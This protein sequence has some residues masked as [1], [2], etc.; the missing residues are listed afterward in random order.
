MNLKPG[1]RLKQY[2]ILE[3]IGAGGM[4]E[5]YR[6][7][8]TNLERD[9][10]IKVLPPEVAETAT[11]LAR[12]EREAKSIAVAAADDPELLELMRHVQ[13]LVAFATEQMKVIE[14]L[15]D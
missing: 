14:A 10:A 7:L 15:A 8:D 12:L 4:G 13:A 2:E 9:V 3:A 5:V 1:T 11:S 6:A